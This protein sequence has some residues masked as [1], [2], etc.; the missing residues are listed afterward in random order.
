VKARN[1]YRNLDKCTNVQKEIA[2]ALTVQVRQVAGKGDAVSPRPVR[3]I[4]LGI[5]RAQ[6]QRWPPS[7]LLSPRNGIP[8]ATP[9]P[10]L[11]PPDAFHAAKKIRAQNRL[12]AM[13]SKSA[14]DADFRR[15]L[16]TS[17]C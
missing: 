2:N 16:S 5:E 17:H 8:A 6:R 9:Q 7:A 4:G 3:H 13:I 11:G 14:T 10:Q 12:T 15:S 1:L